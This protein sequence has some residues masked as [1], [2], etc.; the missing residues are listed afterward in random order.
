MVHYA[1]AT[2]R[3][4]KGDFKYFIY[5]NPQLANEQLVLQ[6][7]SYKLVFE[8]PK[9]RSFVVLPDLQP[10]PSILVTFSKVSPK[11]EPSPLASKNLCPGICMLFLGFD[12][13]ANAT[14][15]CAQMLFTFA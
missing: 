11:V 12:L 15:A 10:L 5:N 13:D 4:A 1:L 7:Y 9:S 6:Y 2:N 14:V 3:D 8:I